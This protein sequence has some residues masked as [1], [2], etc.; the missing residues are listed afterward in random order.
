LSHDRSAVLTVEGGAVATAVMHFEA[1][2]RQTLLIVPT[3]LL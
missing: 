3:D 2:F 1:V